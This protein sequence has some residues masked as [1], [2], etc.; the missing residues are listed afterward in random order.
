VSPVPIKEFYA[1]TRN[2]G[3]AVA[4]L[5]KYNISLATMLQAFG[6]GYRVRSWL[7]KPFGKLPSRVR[8]FILAINIPSTPEEAVEFFKIGQPRVPLYSVETESVMAE[9]L[10]KE[11][12]RSITKLLVNSNQAVD[13]QPNEWARETAAA[14]MLKAAKAD[15]NHK[16]LYVEQLK[17]L[18][19]SGTV[20]KADVQY[21]FRTC[22]DALHNLSN[23]TWFSG[24]RMIVEDAERNIK[25]LQNISPKDFAKAYIEFLEV[26]HDVAAQN[27]NVF[28]TSRPNPPAMQG[29]ATP[30][31]VRFWKRWS[32]ILQ[33]S[34]EMS[35]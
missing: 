4:I 30:L 5:K 24:K 20:S 13:T 17:D 21:T 8:L 34:Q 3:A 32:A 26:Q 25:K 29:I 14:L 22:S 31:Q 27:M 16:L 10:R 2:L 33:G 9:F 1:A 19:R 35:R 28:A 15:V 23:L 18:I 7:N 12:Q 11:S 6:V